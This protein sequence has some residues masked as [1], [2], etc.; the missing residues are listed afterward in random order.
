MT[1]SELHEFIA[2]ST[3]NEKNICQIYAIKNGETVFDDCWHGYTADN[4][5]NV[6]SV[7][8]GVMAILTGI[9]MD[10]GLITSTDQ[11]VLEFFPDYQV[12]R[13]EKTIY[14]VKLE[15]LLTMTAPY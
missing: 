3:G 5:V 14:D 10:K 1:R 2:S 12:K 11:K 9:A 8:K 13:G 15:H 6:M 7:T 4:T